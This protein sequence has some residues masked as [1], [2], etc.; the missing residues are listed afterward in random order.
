MKEKLNYKLSLKGIDAEEILDLAIYR[1]I[2]FQFVRL[3]YNTNI[4]PNQISYAALFFGVLAGVFYAFG[5]EFSFLMAALSFFL[6]NVLD[7]ADGQLARLKK[8]GTRI[9]RIIDGLIDY[10]TAISTFVGIAIALQTSTSMYYEWGYK[11]LMMES[12]TYAW[13]LTVIAALSRALQNMMFDKYRNM[14]L[15]Y[16]Y[17]KSDDANENLEE[18]KKELTALKRLKGRYAAK[19]LMNL[20]YDYTL[21]QNKMSKPVNFDV[22]SEEYK[23]LN[24]LLLRMWS[25]IGSTTHLTLAIFFTLIFRVEIYLYVTIIA[26]NLILITLL[27]IQNI[28][29]N[30]LK[31]S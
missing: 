10:I 30:K 12:A 8:N 7:C 14:Y 27:I 17:G 13:T 29:L 2:S 1:P 16:V 3:I 19:I 4:T 5:S 11:S 22:T 18:Y 25:W 15:K 9:G 20:Y 21:L 23:R 26:G 28:I 6:C 24:R 31:K